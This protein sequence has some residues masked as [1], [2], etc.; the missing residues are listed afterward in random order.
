MSNNTVNDFINT[1]IDDIDDGEWAAIFD[2][3]YEELDV[4]DSEECVNMLLET[5]DRDE[6]ESELMTKFWE[7]FDEITE[8]SRFKDIEINSILREYNNYY[9]LSFS[10]ARSLLIENPDIDWDTSTG[11]YVL[12]A[13]IR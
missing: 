8:L 4:D 2:S 11:G 12:R 13:E 3:I 10:D 7:K 9:G 5:F 6:I 1:Y